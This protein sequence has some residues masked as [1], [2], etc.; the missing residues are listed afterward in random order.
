MKS[1]QLKFRKKPIRIPGIETSEPDLKVP[2]ESGFAPFKGGPYASMYV[3]QPWTIRQY[4]GFSTAEESNTFYK[5]NLA[6]GQTALSVAFD[7]ATHRGYD[8]DHARVRGDVGKAGVAVDTVEDMKILF[9]EIPLDKMSVSMTM[10]GAVIPILAFYIICAEEQGVKPAQLTGTIQN[11]I[12]KEFLVRNTYIY[13]PAASMRLVTDIFRYTQAHMPRFNSISVSGY[14]M[15]EAGAPAHLELAF[16]LANGFE[17]LKYGMKAGLNIDDFAPRI[18]YFFGIGMDFF[19]EIA[20]LRAARVLWAGLVVRAGGKSPKSQVLRAHCQTSG[21][22]LTRQDAFNNIARTSLEALAGVWGGTQSLHTNSLDEALS[23][24]T[25]ETAAIARETQ[26]F[27]QKHA[28]LTDWVD[29]LGGSVLIDELTQDLI[30]QSQRIME[31][32]FKLGGMTIAIQQG[33][34]KRLIEEAAVLKQAGIDSGEEKLIGLNVFVP[35]QDEET[36][37]LQMD[38]E[39]VLH[40]QLTRLARVKKERNTAQVKSLLKNITRCCKSDSANVLEAA[41]DAARARATL[42]EISSAIEV[43][44]SRYQAPVSGLSKIYASHSM[45]NKYYSRA[46]Q[47]VLS[48]ER[49]FGRR[50][51][52][53]IAKLGQDGHDRGAKIIATGFADIGFDVDI[54]PLFQTPGEVARHAVENDVHFIGVSSLS[55]GHQL[56]VPELIEQLKQLGR[57]DIQVMVGGIIPEADKE[58][59]FNCGVLAVF[60]PGTNLAEAAYQLLKLVV[61]SPHV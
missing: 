52:I 60:G 28:G 45:K 40:T 36:R 22:S 4:A 46:G 41:I 43:V 35:E 47:M 55:G 6:A 18:S 15:L 20:K 56:L 8:S 11:D 27:L 12:L 19:L 5:N 42:G 3:S 29:P 21:W 54:G 2:M 49:Q 53:L 50:P 7:L 31:E 10:N 38:N 58:K 9:R 17:Y 59:L 1:D 33:Y 14:H 13:P 23:L 30:D 34:P 37:V 24:P 25:P 48:F 44:F 61:K 57:P 26:L 51:R 39:A 32:I 16:T